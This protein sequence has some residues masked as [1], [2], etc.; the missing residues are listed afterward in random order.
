ML[1]QLDEPA[2][3][4]NRWNDS[5]EIGSGRGRTRLNANKNV[6]VDILQIEK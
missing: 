3:A 1:K 4:Y 5:V 2:F 6:H